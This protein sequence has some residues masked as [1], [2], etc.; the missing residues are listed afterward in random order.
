[1]NQVRWSEQPGGEAGDLGFGSFVSGPGVCPHA[2][3]VD[4]CDAEQVAKG[5]ARRP[6]LGDEGGKEQR[7]GDAIPQ[8]PFSRC[9][10][11]L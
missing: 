5:G 1:M 11:C 3:R 8:L 7:D 2:F 6:C 10:A 4:A 9:H